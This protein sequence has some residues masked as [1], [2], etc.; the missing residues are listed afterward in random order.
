MGACLI[1]GCSNSN[2]EQT[3]STTTASTSSPGSP[4]YAAG[5]I[6]VSAGSSLSEGS[7]ILGYDSARDNYQYLSVWKSE[8]GNWTFRSSDQI[9]VIARDY[10]EGQNFQKLAN[11]KYSSVL[12]IPTMWVDVATTTIAT[13]G[14]K[15]YFNDPKVFRTLI[16]LEMQR[17]DAQNKGDKKAQLYYA[18][19]QRKLIHNINELAAAYKEVAEERYPAGNAPPNPYILNRGQSDFVSCT[20]GNHDLNYC[21]QLTTE[22]SDTFHI[23]LNAMKDMWCQTNSDSKCN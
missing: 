11:I 13:A 16:A 19:E 20:D 14:V 6:V 4:R 2:Q 15:E 1:A 21:L 7:L 3:P 18:G 5:D 10:A 9:R 8:D 12:P 22:Y 17:T 23:T